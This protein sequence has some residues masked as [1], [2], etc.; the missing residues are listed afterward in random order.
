MD[1]RIVRWLYF[2]IGG[3][4]V[5]KYGKWYK[6]IRPHRLTLKHNPAI[7]KW[8]WW[9]FSWNPWVTGIELSRQPVEDL[10]GFPT[11][12]IDQTKEVLEQLIRD[13]EAEQN[14]RL[15]E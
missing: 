3:P 12:K 7:Y 13:L 9:N 11:K 15:G 2:L 5:G 1:K 4:V 10:V 14:D 6:Y 8:M